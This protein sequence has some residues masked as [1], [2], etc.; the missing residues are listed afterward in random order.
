[1]LFLESKLFSYYL[2]KKKIVIDESVE[3]NPPTQTFT[4]IEYAKF[5]NRNEIVHLF[6]Q[7]MSGPNLEQRWLEVVK[8]GDEERIDNFRRKIRNHP[9]ITELASFFFFKIVY[10]IQFLVIFYC[11]L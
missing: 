11:L 5:L 1:L 7:K 4:P 9:E 6:E 2:F 8:T 3:E 10:F